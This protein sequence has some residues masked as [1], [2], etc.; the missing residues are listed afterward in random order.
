MGDSE[1]TSDDLLFPEN[2]NGETL[3]PEQARQRVEFFERRIDEKIRA[4]EKYEFSKHESRALNVFFDLAQE[5]T[6]K[7]DLWALSVVIPKVFFG[8]NARLY[9]LNSYNFV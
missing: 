9:L 4:Y 1:T 2:G 6:D 7:H 8:R 3:R 5:F